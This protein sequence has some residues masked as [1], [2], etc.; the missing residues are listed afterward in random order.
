MVKRYKP[1]EIDELADILKKDGVI[2]VPTDTLYGVC[3][4]INSKRAYDKLIAVKNRPTTKSFPIMCYNEEQ[5]KSIAMVNEKAERLM[6]AFMPGP[7][8]LVLKKNNKLP[9]YITNGKDTIAVRMATS[10]K[11]EE[12]IIKVGCPIF[13]TSANQSGEPTC[14]NL[15]EIEKNCP[16]IDGMMEGIVKYSRGSTIIDC[17][18]EKIKILR[19]GPITAEQIKKVIV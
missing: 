16:L 11:I 2:G 14:T 10:K 9:K 19:Q 5:I 12:L 18:S 4:R 3:A 6:Q 13:M 7:I 17:T 1:N 8:T 15:D